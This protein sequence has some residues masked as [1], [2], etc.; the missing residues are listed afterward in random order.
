MSRRRLLQLLALGAG[1]SFIGACTAA[2]PQP[3]AVPPEATAGPAASEGLANQPVNVTLGVGRS[4]ILGEED[5]WFTHSSL[6]CWEP[7][8]GLD[9]RL[10]PT[11]VLAESWELADDNLSWTFRLRKGVT[12]SDGEPFNGAAVVKNIER[13][14]QISPRRSS[15][16]TMDAPRAYGDLAEVSAPDEYTVVFRHNKP[17]PMME[18]TMSNFFSAMF[19]PKSFTAEGNF[20]G[21]PA[22]T[23]PFKLV[24]WERD[25]WYN[26]AR[27]EG[28]WGTKAKVNTLRFE[29]IADANTRVAALES[30]QVEA[31][32]ELGVLGLPQAAALRGRE[33][34]IVQAGPITLAQWLHFNCSKP[35]FDDLRM[36]QAVAFAI[37]REVIV[38]DLAFGFGNAATGILSTLSQRWFSPKGIVPYAP[39][40]AQQLAQAALQGQRVEVLLPFDPNSARTPRELPEYLQ[41]LLRPLGIDVQLQAVEPA[42]LTDMQEKGEWQLRLPNGFGWA[43][44][45]PDF[46]FRPHLHSQGSANVTQ[47]GGYRNESADKLIDEA[48]LERDYQKRFAMCEQ[49]QQLAADEVPTMVLYDVVSPYAFRNTIS[50]LGLRITYQPTLELM[51]KRMA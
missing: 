13:N 29:Q 41:S 11:P 50:N 28:Y 21:I 12:F 23:G 18:A 31:L 3:A 4:L 32:V 25:Q 15:F 44:G 51:E 1:A 10:N 35:P 33:D 49:L 47:K 36:R 26:L 7:L 14:I 6:M 38:K 34:I 39:D 27:N 19:S 20:A 22:T 5:P 37:D 48:V 40:R 16:F 30:G 9:D 46:R 43:N 42:V 17:F 24:A 2:Q 8:V 45:D